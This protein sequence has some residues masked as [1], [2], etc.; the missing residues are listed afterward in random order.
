MLKDK[1][2]KLQQEN[3]KHA[4]ERHHK[5]GCLA[6]DYNVLLVDM[7]EKTPLLYTGNVGDYMCSITGKNINNLLRLVSIYHLTCSKELSLK[8]TN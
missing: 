1:V 8:L 6:I 2:T 5:P 4:M 7:E 3:T